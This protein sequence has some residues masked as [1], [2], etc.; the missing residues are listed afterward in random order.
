METHP[1]TAPAAGPLQRM[2]EA[3]Q[4]T[5][6]SYRELGSL[7][8]A[9]KLLG[10]AALSYAGDRFNTIALITL[11]FNLGD[12]ALG[13]GGMLALFSLPR[14]L[15]QGPAGALVD[16]YP[17]PRLL[18]VSQVLLAVVAAAFAL[19]AVLPSIW[20]LYGLVL[21]MG[22]LRTVALPAFELQLMGIV[23]PERRGT[24]NAVHLLMMTAGDFVGPLLGGLILVWL[25]AVPLFL[26]NGLSFLV[27]TVAIMRLRGAQRSSTGGHTEE[28]PAAQAARTGEGYLTLLRRPDVAL[29]T[30]VTVFTSA[31]VMA[32]MALFVVQA[33]NLGLGEGGVGVFFAVISIGTAIG[34]TLAGAGSY[35]GPRAILIA[36]GA[37]VVEALGLVL[38][39]LAGG[40]GLAIVGLILFGLTAD[41]EEIAMI[42]YFQNRLPEHLYGRFFSLFLIAAGAGGLIGPI[43]GPL[44][45]ETWS[46]GIALT[47]LALPAL[48]LT[49]VFALREGG[50]QATMPV[51]S[52]ST[53]EPEVVGF[54]LFGV[55]SQSDLLPDAMPGGRALAPRL[56]RLI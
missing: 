24:A 3:L 32:A 54:G 25:G 26:L 39:G 38:F 20:L 48:A 31:L 41:L 34:G 1:S 42:T 53:P 49:V 10:A 4:Q 19:L 8:D 11:S 36:A 9:R 2:Q 30:A 28:E 15:I 5:V 47:L 6:G 33:I 23:P 51:P 46:V 7:P 35:L 14:F 13:V 40:L 27:V 17:G 56:H 55:P 18:V 21:T 45:A 12:G 16:R 22:T 52:S 29:Y 50:I 43:A 37:V 44:L